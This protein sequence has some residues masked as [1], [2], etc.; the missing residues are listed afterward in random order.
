[1]IIYTI[2]EIDW[3]VFFIFTAEMTDETGL[4]VNIRVEESGE[5][6]VREKNIFL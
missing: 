5:R 4:P 2:F 1:M 6:A 3:I